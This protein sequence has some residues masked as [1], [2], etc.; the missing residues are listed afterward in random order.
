MLLLVDEYD[1]GR[2][3]R[4][5]FAQWLEDADWY[6]LPLSVAR[7]L[8][9]KDKLEGLVRKL[10][11]AWEKKLDKILGKESTAVIMQSSTPKNTN[12]GNFANRPKEEVRAAAAK[13]GA[14][15]HTG[16]F[17]SMDPEQQRAIASMGGKA[18]SGSFQKGSERA[19]EAGR[20]GGL[21]RKKNV[22]TAPTM[23]N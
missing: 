3:M 5:F 6:G 7:A 20:K 12:P 10:I 19:R 1:I 15:S 13:G 21:A 22:G 23:G 16:G 11:K 8:G 17:A 2:I 9:L 4:H 14:A 18:S